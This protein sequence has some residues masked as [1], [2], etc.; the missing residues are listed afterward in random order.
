MLDIFPCNW[1]NLRINDVS[2]KLLQAINLLKKLI[3][4]SLHYIIFRLITSQTTKLLVSIYHCYGQLYQGQYHLLQE[5][6]LKYN[7]TLA[8]FRSFCTNSVFVTILQ[9]TNR[10]CFFGK[11][12]LSCLFM[13]TGSDSVLVT[14]YKNSFRCYLFSKALALLFVNNQ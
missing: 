7:N 4:F 9:F 2:Q 5:F 12:L 11:S 14:N 13:I 3:V 6:N 10:V 1:I 8:E